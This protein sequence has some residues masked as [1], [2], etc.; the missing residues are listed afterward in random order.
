V[1][2]LD[3]IYDAQLKNRAAVGATTAAQRIEKLQRIERAVLQRRNEIRAA[4]WEDFLK[5]A[6]EVDVSEVFAIVSEARYARRRLKRWLRPHRVMPMPSLLGTRSKVVYEPKGIVL[7][8]APWN[9]PFNLTLGPMV[10]AIAAGNCVILKPSEMTPAS[11]AMMKRFVS[12]LFPENEVAVVE[13]G[14]EVATDLL[15][16][17]FD[18]I[19]FTGSP[20]VGRVVMRAAAEHLTPV[21]LELGGKSPAIV[22]RTADLGEAA[23]RLGWGKFLNSGQVCIAPDYI[24]VHEEVRDAFV[25]KLK[26]ALQKFGTHSGIVVNERH[27]S[28]VRGLFDSAVAE[29]AE[30]I[31]GGEMEGRAM[32]PTVIGNVAAQSKVME[33]EIFG[34][35]LPILT[36]RDIPEALQFIRQREKPLALYLF[37]RSRGVIREVLSGTSAGGTVINHTLIHFYQLNLPFGGVGQSGMGRGHGFSG[38]QTFSNPRGVVEQWTRFSG[39]DLLFPPYNALKRKLI[40]FTIKYL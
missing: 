11:S 26:R 5:P 1:S 21:T 18:H 30:V 38:F 9:F 20:S 7:I 12:D 16:R 15:K 39:I 40:D 33:E 37:S 17:K 32:K 31:A 10:S 8:I 27:A 35:V 34:P 23:R 24:L 3:R 13:G 19:F 14:P 25:E 36:Y 28:R 4:M 22:D 29:G 2:E 6:E